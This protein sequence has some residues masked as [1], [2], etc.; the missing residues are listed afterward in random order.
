MGRR[1][2]RG[3]D[4]GSEHGRLCRKPRR[5]LRREYLDSKS[6]HLETLLELF[7]VNPAERDR[8]LCRTGSNMRRKQE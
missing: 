8:E 4:A 1:G 5:K 2:R 3:G 6:Y 7:V